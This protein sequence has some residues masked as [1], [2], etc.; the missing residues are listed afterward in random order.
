MT[1]SQAMQVLTSTDTVNWYTPSKYIEMTRMYNC[2][3]IPLRRL[4]ALLYQ[5]KVK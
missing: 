2:F 4:D 5:R 1:Q 3:T